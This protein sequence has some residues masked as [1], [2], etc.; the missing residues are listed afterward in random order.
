MRQLQQP[1]GSLA[2]YLPGTPQ[3]YAEAM[4]GY[5]LLLRG[6]RTGDQAAIAAGL[7]AISYTVQPGL[8]AGPGLDSVFKQ[9]GVAAAYT[10]A[11]AQLA[12]DERFEERRERWAAWLRQVRPV[13]LTSTLRGT[14]NK[15][16]VEAV[17]QLEL[18]RSGIAA[19]ETGTVLADPEAAR[20]RIEALINRRWPAA[21][22]AQSRRGPLGPMAVSSDGPT[23][24]L[25]YH[26]LA[27]AM[28]DRAVSLLGASSSP[29]ARD[30]LRRMARA[31]WALTAPDGDLAYWGRSQEQ[32]WA[33][34]LTAA[35]ADGLDEG[36]EAGI[37]DDAVGTS[38]AEGLRSRLA[39]RLIGQHGFGPYGVWIVPALR[40]DRDAGR[41]AMDDYAAN[42]V[43][44]GLTLVGAEWTLAEPATADTPPPARLAGDRDGVTRLGRGRASFAVSRHGNV[45]FAV[46]M[47]SGFGGHTHDPRYAFGLM[48]VKRRT[49]TGWSDAV[50]AAPRSVGAGDAA[51]PWL[52]LPGELMAEPYGSRIETARDGVVIV[53][54][55]FRTP[56]GGLV[57]RARFTFTPTAR[58]VELSFRIRA[59]EEF[60]VADFRSA[61]AAPAAVKLTVARGNRTPR[62]LRSTP[63]VRTGFAS[64][65][66]GP[67]VR[68]AGRVRAGRGGTLTWTPR[69]R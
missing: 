32:S 69:G 63:R 49:A 19:G 54:G 65:T 8:R 27:L 18:L 4:V 42:G 37:G 51:G 34:A 6:A 1:D 43:Y 29:S 3:P 50:P 31:S 14:S 25:A 62:A 23:H 2:E 35:G 61:N 9:L 58:G 41:A 11:D 17:A 53:H 56:T 59:G 40:S 44:N 66:L 24:P 36:D 57:R 16:L 52:V 55:G 30:A 28:A 48:A 13:H 12:G 47:R 60:E 26:G 7:R 46:R 21:V 38:R 15:H 10:L 5:A 20:R 45:W 33:L 22:E 64:A 67:V 39:A 68:V